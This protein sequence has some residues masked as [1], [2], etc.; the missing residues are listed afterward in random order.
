VLVL[1]WVRLLLLGVPAVVALGLG[2]TAPALLLLAAT[3]PGYRVAGALLAVGPAVLVVWSPALVRTVVA[4]VAGP[5]VPAEP[6]EVAR[7]ADAARAEGL[8]VP[9]VLVAAADLPAPVPFRGLRRDLLVLSP[10]QVARPQE[11]VAAVA[12][13]RR[14]GDDRLVLVL[15]ALVIVL[16]SWSSALRLVTTAAR[17]GRLSLLDRL[18]T[19]VL[20]PLAP[21]AA[22]GWGV[23]WAAVQVARAVLPRRL[24]AAL[25]ALGGS[26]TVVRS[27]P[28][29]DVVALGDGVRMGTMLAT[30]HVEPRPAADRSDL[31]T[32]WSTPR[33]LAGA[34][35]A[36][37][38]GGA[39]R[40]VVA[41]LVVGVGTYA[42]LGRVP[43]ERIAWPWEA[44][45]QVATVVRVDAT[46][47]DEGRSLVERLG[48]DV[49]TSYA[50]EVRL[51]DGGTVDLVPGSHPLA[52]GDEVRVVPDAEAGGRARSL[53]QSSA[54]DLVIAS[55]V[56]LALG[57][58][59]LRGVGGLSTLADQRRLAQADHDQRVATGRRHGRRRPRPFLGARA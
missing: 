38:L 54:A 19:A 21:V 31:R 43:A 3:A 50:A 27:R 14:T 46:R 39:A 23:C 47:E 40:V 36:D 4:A 15:G 30:G 59:L 52:V 5:V 49:G 26:T 22:L 53:T 2:M 10:A 33:A 28:T 8:P 58:G 44:A 11:S 51:P 57:A 1:R 42:G 7:L 37:L 25:L 20:L 16:G 17:P 24:T 18:P 9:T 6:D 32:W 29:Q 35:S 12:A 55:G 34:V 41:V 48:A 56:M 13:A 45:P